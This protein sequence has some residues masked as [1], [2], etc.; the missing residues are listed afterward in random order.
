[1]APLG[2]PDIAATSLGV[3]ERTSKVRMIQGNDLLYTGYEL[4]RL[5]LAS[6]DRARIQQQVAEMSLHR[7]RLTS[8]QDIDRCI[9][10]IH[11]YEAVAIIENRC[12]IGSQSLLEVTDRFRW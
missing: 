5:T 8:A 6:H 12:W 7:K 10:K 11:A 9:S 3:S 1:M 2:V 4:V